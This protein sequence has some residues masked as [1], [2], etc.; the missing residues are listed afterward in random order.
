MSRPDEYITKRELNCILDVNGAVQGRPGCDGKDGKDG[1]EGPRGERGPQGQEGKQG[2]VG[3]RG[4]DGRRGERGLDGKDGCNGKD[5]RDGRDGED[6]REGPIGPVGQKGQDGKDGRDG[7]CGEDGVGIEGPKGDKGDQGEQ[8]E[9]GVQGEMGVKGDTGEQGI[10]G[11]QGPKGDTGD[12]GDK[13]DTGETGPTG[14]AGNDGESGSAGQPGQDGDDGFTPTISCTQPNSTSVVISITNET[15]TETKTLDVGAGGATGI[16]V[17]EA[18]ALIQ[19]LRCCNTGFNQVTNADDSVTVTL[20]Q[21]NGSPVSFTLPAGTQG[22]QGPQGEQG[23]QGI[24]GV[25]GQDGQDGAM[26]LQGIQGEQGPPGQDGTGGTVTEQDII[27]AL[28]DL[29]M[30]CIPKADGSGFDVVMINSNGQTVV[31]S[32]G[33]CSWPACTC[34]CINVVAGQTVT[35][36]G[37]SVDG[38]SVAWDEN[39]QVAQVAGQANGTAVYQYNTAGEYK[40]EI[41]LNSACDTL[42]DWNVT[43]ATAVRYN[44]CN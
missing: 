30:S 33:G 42:S 24:Q 13:G 39:N 20:S 21:D 5:G 2:C 19:Q 29:S 23:I 40:L 27:D 37:T 32:A 16:S 15:G 1:G 14:P 38:F 4:P 11:I 18:T 25:P 36:R 6:G 3:E 28:T 31:D 26:G 17:A 10:Q 34:V 41:C 12:K 22:E 35:V 44:A 9:Q 43:G 8:G 7:C